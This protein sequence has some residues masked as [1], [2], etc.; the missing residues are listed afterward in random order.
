MKIP[1]S[2][3]LDREGQYCVVCFKG[4]VERV[5]KDN[6]TF[7]KCESCGK[8]EARCLVIDNAVTWWVD[9]D[10]TYWHES[11]AIIVVNKE[12]KILC[13]LR[14]L[15]PFAY[16]MPA[17]HVDKDEK[18]EHAARRELEEETGIVA[19][20]GLQHLGTFDIRGDSCRR[21]CDDHKWHLYKY[22]VSDDAEVTL[23]D[24]ASE[25]HWY[26]FDELEALK[27]VTY[28]LTVIIKKFGK[29]LAK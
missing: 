14:Q 8:T 15:F 5:M 23:S 17:G 1:E 4:P 13:M 10:R 28:G 3:P 24:E 27:P 16:T 12:K 11:V 21:G 18:P 25:A 9:A 20:G 6:L 7:Y 29:S 2:I 26:S 19:N 22:H